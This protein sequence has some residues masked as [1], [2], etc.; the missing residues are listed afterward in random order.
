LGFSRKYNLEEKKTRKRGAGKKKERKKNKLK[1]I[2][3]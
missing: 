1:I 2:L 3:K